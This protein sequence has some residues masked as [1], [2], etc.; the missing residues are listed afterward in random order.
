MSIAG[1]MSTFIRVAESTPKMRI[2]AEST[3]MV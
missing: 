2:N 1:K 3:A